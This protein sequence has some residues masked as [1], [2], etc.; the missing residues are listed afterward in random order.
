MGAFRWWNVPNANICSDADDCE[1]CPSGANRC[2]RLSMCS[3][4]TPTRM[5]RRVNPP[6]HS[7][8]EGMAPVRKRRTS[9]PTAPATIVE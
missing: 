7:T 5:P 1:H 4:G 8:I 2:T 3:A 6:T 9:M